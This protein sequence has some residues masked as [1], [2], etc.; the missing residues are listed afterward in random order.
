M[1]DL[2]CQTGFAFA[3]S[4]SGNLKVHLATVGFG[5]WRLMQLKLFMSPV[6]LIADCNLFQLDAVSLCCIS[7]IRAEKSCS[8]WNLPRA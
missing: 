8:A 5:F 6:E 2:W 4:T 7:S 1:E 3:R